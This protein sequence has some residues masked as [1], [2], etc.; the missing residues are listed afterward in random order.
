M[1]HKEYRRV[2]PNAD[3]A[4][5]LIHGILGTPNHFAP[6]LPLI[7]VEY[8]VHN[9]LLKGHGGSVRAFSQASMATWEAQVK[10]ALAELLSTHKK[11]YI[12]AHS[13]GT[14]LA[15]EQAV[16]TEGIGGMFLLAVPLRLFLRPVL[17]KTSMKVWLN[18]IRPE[19]AWGL[20]ARDCCSITQE[21][22]PLLYLGWIPRFLELFRKIRQVRKALPGVQVPC[23]VYLSRKDEM[24]S[25]RSA[26]LLA[27]NERFLVQFLENSGHFYYPPQVLSHLQTEFS[28][29]IK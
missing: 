2:V 7:P 6:F 10:A 26:R 20:A 27:C 11:V 4:V 17:V 15:L 25:V 12:V 13:L 9:L 28:K 8:S 23:R 19:D 29:F 18:R 22:N 21:R 5:L 3:T 1:V 16:H 24:V 14:L